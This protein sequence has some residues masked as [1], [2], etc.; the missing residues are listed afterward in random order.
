MTR[1][2]DILQI[3]TPLVWLGMALGISV[4]ETPLKFRAPGITRALGLGIGRLVFRA[5]NLTE[6]VLLTVCTLALLGASPSRWVVALTAALWAVLL[7][8]LLGL[9]PALDRRATLIIDGATPPP[10]RLHH[11]YIALEGLKILTL[12]TLAT[13][14]PFGLLP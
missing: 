2:R 7:V 8:Q 5:L 14:L 9:R 3:G 4:L 1:V 12:P 10:S 13:L 6:L 11:L